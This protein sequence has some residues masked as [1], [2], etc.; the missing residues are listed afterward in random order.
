MCGSRLAR[1]AGAGLP[2]VAAREERARDRARLGFERAH[3]ATI[4]AR[5]QPVVEV[6]FEERDVL[7]RR[8]AVDVL[9]GDVGPGADLA[10]R[11]GREGGFDVGV[12][13]RV[14]EARRLL[15]GDGREQ[16]EARGRDLSTR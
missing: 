3:H 10:Q 7:G 11:E 14:A 12:V 15:A 8:E 6:A 16:F 5:L 2:H 13:E 9:R 4:V 1:G